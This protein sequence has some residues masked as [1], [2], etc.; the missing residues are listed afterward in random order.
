MTGVAE[1]YFLNTGV[2]R[3]SFLRFKLLTR[4]GT[5]IELSDRPT[6]SI[7][8]SVSRSISLNFE[9]QYQNISIFF[10][11]KTLV[12]L[13]NKYLRTVITAWWMAILNIVVLGW[14]AFDLEWWTWTL[15]Y[16]SRLVKTNL[17]I[18]VRFEFHFR[19]IIEYHFYGIFLV[20]C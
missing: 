16:V 11:T 8:L 12:K 19:N 15:A 7:G 3:S 17:E 13:T 18:Y 20:W 9:V 2:C 1:L 5:N 6:T 14:L 4:N 10:Y